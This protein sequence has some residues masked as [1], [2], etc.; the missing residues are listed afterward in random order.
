MDITKKMAVELRALEEPTV[1][2][3]YFGGQIAPNRFFHQICCASGRLRRPIRYS[4]MRPTRVQR[5]VLARV[6][7]IR[8]GREAKRCSGMGD[9]SAVLAGAEEKAAG[10]GAVPAKAH[11]RAREM[12][13]AAQGEREACS[14]RCVWA[15]ETS[16]SSQQMTQGAK[17]R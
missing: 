13:S 1:E 9:M 11:C 17:A 2:G 6:L 14:V 10:V 7:V 5:I 16:D 4:A 12:G 3:S 8:V 15:E